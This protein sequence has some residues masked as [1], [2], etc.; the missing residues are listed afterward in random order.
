MWEAIKKARERYDEL[1]SLLADE[2]VLKDRNLLLR[3]SRERKELDPLVAKAAEMERVEQALADAE[4]IRRTS[5]DKEMTEMARQEA[6]SLRAARQRTEQ[7][8]KELLV[9]R[10]PDDVKN[11]IVEIR[12][13]T[14]GEE[15]AL[16]AADLHRMYSRFAEGQ[17]W[18]VDVLSSS[19]TGVGGFKEV[20]FAVEGRGAYGK[21]K[22]ESGVHRV[23]RIPVTEASGRIHTSAVTVAILPEADE[24][25][26]AVKPEDIRVDV[27]RSS[28]P[29][30]QSVNTTDSA[31][32]VTHIP[33]GLVV[34]CQDEKSQ[35]KNKAK[36]LK[37][38]R[39]RL[40][41]KAKAEQ[42]QER[43]RSRK[44]QV[45]KGDRSEK[46]RT[47]NFPQSRVT[48]HRIGLSLHNLEQVL[49]G[50]M[51]DLIDALSAN[52]SEARLKAAGL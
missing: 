16:F 20:I 19:P 33:S 38:L 31:V 1:A 27:F 10:D 3:Y 30:G 9:P 48:D 35:H 23:Q 32:R 24:I 26:I 5:E 49:D 41:D 52:D 42:D 6:E 36:A 40:L 43:S 25:D 46:I 8:L 18:K 47:Y 14:G 44:Q 2:K 51:E 39:S 45:G 28:G 29:G 13:G 50:D 7:E 15:A 11:T 21:L 12:A 34:T 22:Y 17:G 37:V 4:E